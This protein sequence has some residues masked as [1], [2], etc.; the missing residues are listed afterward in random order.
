MTYF[1]QYSK[2]VLIL[3][4]TLVP[5]SLF[6]Q[7]AEPTLNVYLPIER[8]E[9]PE[10][11]AQ[12]T[13]LLTNKLKRRINVHTSELWHQHQKGLRD[14]KYHIVFTA[15]HFAAWH[16]HQYNFNALLKLNKPIQYL[17]LANHKDTT[18]FEVSDLANQSVCIQQ[19]INLDYL[20]LQTQFTDSI[21]APLIEFTVP[22]YTAL[23]QTTSTCRGFMVIQDKFEQLSKLTQQR[24]TKLHQSQRYTNYA[25][26]A[27]PDISTST[28]KAFQQVLQSK[29]GQ[30]ILKSLNQHYC[31]NCTLTAAKNNDYPV[32]YM[33]LLKKHWVE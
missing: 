33:A 16:I 26:L 5:S 25:W 10:L 2:T 3:W 4:L 19:P 9:L 24:W 8:I 29:S 31:A 17:L 6:A 21:S 7:D 15:P 27:H 22:P 23:T 13:E 12:L 28:A 30:K 11:P 1:H 32:E 20:I 18:I 14:G